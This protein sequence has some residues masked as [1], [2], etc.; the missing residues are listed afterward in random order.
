MPNP[1]R[2]V[3][4][5]TKLLLQLTNE[6]SSL[7]WVSRG[8][9]VYP[10]YYIRAL[11]M[12]R[13]PWISRYTDQDGSDHLDTGLCSVVIEDN[14]LCVFPDSK[15]YMEYNFSLETLAIII[16][17]CEKHLAESDPEHFLLAIAEKAMREGERGKPHA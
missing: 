1:P 3:P 14:Q 10:S 6:A 7:D 2:L 8:Y 17:S 5:C 9:K 4:E 11:V 16:Q 12:E 15:P 13:V